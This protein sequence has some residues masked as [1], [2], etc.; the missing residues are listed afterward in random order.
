MVEI[1]GFALLAAILHECQ[2]L[3]I[4]VAAINDKTR[5]ISTISRK[6]RGLWTVYRDIYLMK[7]LNLMFKIVL[8]NKFSFVSYL[9]KFNHGSSESTKYKLKSK[10]ISYSTYGLRFAQ[11]ITPMNF[12]ILIFELTC[13]GLFLSHFFLFW[14]IFNSKFT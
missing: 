6:N 13:S 9:L 5:Y 14:T 2:N 1:A 11:Y 8:T 4:K 7:A 3:K 12:L 10:M